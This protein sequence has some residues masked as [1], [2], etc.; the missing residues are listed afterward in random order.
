MTANSGCV[1]IIEDDPGTATLQRRCL[2]R[3][4]YR[5]FT[6]ANRRQAWQVL[7]E[8]PVELILLDYK[9]QDRETGL[10]LLAE[11]NDAGFE[12]PCI[13]VT[14]FGNEQLAIDAFRA[15][16]RDFVSKSVT[17]LDNLSQAVERVFR[18]TR[19]REQLRR[20]DE[21]RRRLLQ[22]LGERVKELTLLREA[23][24]HIQEASLTTDD[25]IALLVELL[26]PGFQHP[27]QTKA[28]I[29]IGPQ[30]WTGP[31]F[32]PSPAMLRRGLKLRSGLEL[33]LEVSLDD[34]VLRSDGPPFL[35]EE[36]TL[37]ASLAEMLAMHFDRQQAADELRRNEQR[38]RSLIEASTVLVWTADSTGRISGVSPVRHDVTS[39][40]AMEAIGDG[41]IGLVHPDDI[42]ALIA[43]WQQSLQL[44]RPHQAVGRIRRASGGYLHCDIRAVPIF[45]EHGTVLEWFGTIHDITQQR[46]HET[47]LG[48]LATIVESSDD[49]IVSKTL[50][51][52]VLSWNP[53]AERTF[54]YAMEEMVGQSIDGIELTGQR[55]PFLQQLHR[56]A[57]GEHVEPF[58][59]TTIRRDGARID[60]LVHMS[61]IRDGVGNVVAASSIMHEITERRAAERRRHLQN[62]TLQALSGTPS[63][64]EATRMLTDV[65][66]EA[67]GWNVGGLWLLDQR[68]NGLRLAAGNFDRDTRFARYHEL[69]RGLTFA[70]GVGL[71]G[72]AWRQGKPVWI[73]DFDQQGRYPRS[74]VAGELKFHTGLA[75]PL[76][77]S[78]RTI[79]AL[80]FFSQNIS[81]PTPDDL[82]VMCS[83]VSQFALFIDRNATDAKRAQLAEILEAST[84]FVGLADPAEN[85]VYLNKAGRRMV[86]FSELENLSD[87]RIEQIGPK[88]VL[89]LLRKE[90][91]PGAIRHGAWAGEAAIWNRDQ[92]EVPVSMLVLSHRQ[93]QGEAQFFSMIGRDI[94]E[95]RQAR[96]ALQLHDRAMQATSEGIIITGPLADDTPILYANQAFLSLTRYEAAEV[97]GRNC[98]FLQGPET[99]RATLARLRQCVNREEPCTEELLNYRADGSA[100][101]NLVSITPVRDADGRATHFV[102]TQR[103]VS[104]R[105]R[106]EDQLRQTQKIEAIGSLAGG[107]AHDFNNMLTVILGYG[108][109]ARDSLPAASETNGL[110]DEII[111]TAQRA[112]TLTSQLLAFSRRQVIAPQLVDV[113]SI[114]TALQRLLRPLISEAIV[115]RLSLASD[116]WPVKV[117]PSQ[118][119]QI[120]MNLVINGRDAMPSGGQITISTSNSSLHEASAAHDSELRTGDWVLLSVRD[121]GQGMSKETLARAFEPFFTTKPKGKGTGMGLATV[122]GIVKQ[123]GGHIRVVSEIDQGTTVSVYLPRASDSPSESAASKTA[124]KSSKSGVETVL[125][126]EDEAAVREFACHVLREQGYLI[127]AASHGDEAIALFDAEADGVDA[128]ITDV[129]MPGMGGRELADT[130]LRAQPSL[131]VLYLSGY[132]DDVISHQGVLEAG[133]TFL[134]KPFTRDALTQK[135]RQVLDG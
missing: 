107:I 102:G 89:D 47:T 118:F 108:E 77:V 31:G 21:D 44:K 91:I 132:S 97:M 24:R 49:A 127:L 95:E 79:G 125:L 7:K 6:A 130:L 112:A 52:V 60:V 120:V 64:D 70:K 72:E 117:D 119:E 59:T 135:L 35:Q 90:A 22:A 76:V 133:T 26:P 66:C 105:K 18:D 96:E 23:S 34:P 92:V 100:F 37:L 85:I 67:F 113:N 11:L 14:G 36:E 101:W 104:E 16:A 5:V 84:D 15:G 30:I 68:A 122:Y 82:A 87:F 81:Q 86:G 69:S 8:T 110:L 111:S 115:T 80:E 29:R 19:Q 54:G 65:I 131:K 93:P 27:E 124:A 123:S 17:Y 126:V 40:E 50:D 62:A 3:I 71:P 41:W 129:I 46:E 4:G 9:L 128:L 121:T 43:A 75:F 48:R 134:N 78:D 83:L 42:S 63:V 51:G 33:V 12:I 53:G 88:W 25:L 1:L 32:R 45:D 73:S 61:P 39:S 10:D 13:V 57:R 58:E 116:V 94:S 99:D 56:I 114:V 106:L 55:V 103:D 2:E 28:Q 38:Y 74:G 98:R 109:M 20:S